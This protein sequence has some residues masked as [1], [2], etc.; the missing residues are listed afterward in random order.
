M[1][2]IIR[3]I[4][5]R[6]RELVRNRRHA[7]RHKVHLNAVVSLYNA[8]TTKV[9]SSHKQPPVLEGYACDLSATGLALVMPAIRIGD[10]YLTHQEHA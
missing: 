2:E 10:H 9:D 6:L 7:I 4:A 8:K 3:A 1:P 5:G